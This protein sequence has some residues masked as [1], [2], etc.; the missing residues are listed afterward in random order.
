MA[1]WAKLD[2]DLTRAGATTLPSRIWG[3]LVRPGV[4]AVVLFRAQEALHRAG[5]RRSAEIVCALNAFL[6]GAELLVG[7]EFGPGLV[8][9]HPYGIVVGNGAQ[10]GADCTLL[11]HATLGERRGDGRDSP[12]Y[13]RLGNG[14]TIGAGA[15]VLGGIHVGDGSHIGAAA[16]VLHDVPPGRFAVGQPARVVEGSRAGGPETRGRRSRPR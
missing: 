8:I 11:H 9:R 2:A 13:P 5:R 4:R 10:A 14:V 15:S 7:C 12:D 16:V 6:S 1:L 3:F